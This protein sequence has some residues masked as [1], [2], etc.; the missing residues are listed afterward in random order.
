MENTMKACTLG[1]AEPNREAEMSVRVPHPPVWDIPCAPMDRH[2][3]KLKVLR[4]RHQDSA[5]TRLVAT[6]GLLTGSGTATYALRPRSS[7]M[8]VLRSHLAF[9]LFRLSYWFKQPRT[10]AA[11]V[12]GPTASARCARTMILA[13]SGIEFPG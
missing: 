8:D 10:L 9:R 4:A 7:D 3:R 2:A 5:M 11:V 1:F 12:N 6:I 13:I